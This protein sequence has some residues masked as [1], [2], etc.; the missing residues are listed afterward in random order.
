M[1]VL[2][3]CAFLFFGIVYV[4]HRSFWDPI[5][6]YTVC[7][8]KKSSKIWQLI[9]FKLKGFRNWK[10]AV[11]IYIVL[12][13]SALNFN[14]IGQCLAN[15]EV[16]EANYRWNQVYRFWVDAWLNIISFACFVALVHLLARV[17]CI[18]FYVNGTCKSVKNVRLWHAWTNILHDFFP[19]RTHKRVLNMQTLT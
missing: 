1:R 3:V 15:K 9:T 18:T 13:N 19:F 8:R 12:T 6:E 14:E 2:N 7:P 5:T 16:F 10:L 4:V 17:R 11:I